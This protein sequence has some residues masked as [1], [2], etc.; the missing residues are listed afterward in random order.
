MR[1]CTLLEAVPA[2]A[3][4]ARR[5]ESVCVVSL[6]SRASSFLTKST[7]G[8][9]VNAMCVMMLSRSSSLPLTKALR[10]TYTMNRCM[11]Q[12][13]YCITKNFFMT[14]KASHFHNSQKK[15]SPKFS[16][17][18]AVLSVLLNSV[19]LLVISY[20]DITVA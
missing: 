19:L 5:R 8:L 1:C 18:E 4:K 13:A 7:R 16:Q 11:K 20:N 9:L 10:S 17:V 2:S 6:R 12:A 14:C 3:P 15:F